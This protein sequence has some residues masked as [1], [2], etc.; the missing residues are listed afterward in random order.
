MPRPLRVDREH[1][2]DQAMHLF[3]TRGYYATSLKDIERALDMRPGSI[4]A[5]FGSKEGLFSAALE[6]YAGTLGRELQA[7]LDR[8]ASPL[9]GIRGYFHEIARACTV[10]ARDGIRPVRACMVIKTVL[11][12]GDHEPELARQ[13]NRVLE[14]MEHALINAICRA[15][16]AGEIRADADPRRLARF[17]QA[18]IIGLRTFAQRTVSRRAVTDLA[19]DLARSLDLYTA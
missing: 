2:L 12:L 6:R 1:A 8:A 16:K 10:P 11:E 3:W 5:A 4:Y 14:Q 17:L 19:D 7:V 9:Q 13:A 18:Q 15:Q